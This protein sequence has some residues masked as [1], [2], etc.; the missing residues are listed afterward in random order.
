[1]LIQNDYFDLFVQEENVI[2]RLKQIGYPLKSFDAI[3]REFPR[4]KIGSFTALRE[5]LTEQGQE[6][7]IGTWLPPIEVS[8]SSNRMTAQLYFN[9]TEKHFEENKQQ[10]LL[11]AEQLLNHI[12]V[13]HGRKSLQDITLKSREPILVAV[14]TEP[15]KGADAMI[16]YMNIPE[17][18]PVIREDGSANYYEMNFVTPVSQGDWLGE[19]IPP[20]EGISGTDVLGN[21]IPAPR[22]E[23][24]KL[25]FDRKSVS[26]V[27]E[28]D[29]LVLRAS[30]GGALEWSDGQIRVGKQLIIDGDVGPE[31]GSITFDG[32]VTVYGTV[33]DSYSI[34]ATGDI[35]IEGNEGITNAKEIQSLEGDVYIKGGIFGGGET[36]VE[37]KGEIYI[38]HANNCKLYGKE[39]HVG[40]YLLGT[41]IIAERVLVDQNRGKIIGGR[42]EALSR[43]EC[44]Y[45]GNRHERTTILYTKGIDKDAIYKEIQAKAIEVKE[46]QQTIAKLEQHA[47]QFAKVLV[48]GPGVEADTLNKTK[49]TIKA[50]EEEIH[51]LDK[52]IQLGLQKIK[53]AIPAEIEV[54][55]Q[56]YPGV[57]IQIGSK[58]STLHEPTKGRFALVDGVLNV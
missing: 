19:K 15:V 14:G 1:M 27:W 35:A 51:K 37:A 48:G 20:Q 11:E 23:D 30:H 57:V 3:T 43:I 47:A 32:A 12:G 22:G 38:K 41:E 6:H 21:R 31:T 24:A 53:T 16:T 26:E 44:A 52:E 8:I 17:R 42:I 58:T 33:L 28:E 39:I 54:M 55:I 4:L 49:E 56:A 10:I 9:I 29:R 18:R 50:Y 2:L 36:I 46:H 45:V 13:I 40:F 5:A 7:N 34:H 25:S